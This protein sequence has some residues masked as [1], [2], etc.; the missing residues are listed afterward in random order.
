MKHLPLL[1]LLVLGCAT[2]DPPAPSPS[3]ESTP[4]RRR[5]R[6]PR[7]DADA[8]TPAPPVDP[9]LPST[10]RLAPASAPTVQFGSPVITAS[11][12][13]DELRG[14]YLPDGRVVCDGEVPAQ[15]ASSQ[16]PYEPSGAM[17][18]R[19]FEPV[20]PAVLAC[21]P[22]GDADGRFL[23]R[24][25]VS[26]T[27]LPQEVAFPEGTTEATATCVGRALCGLRLTAFRAVFVTVPYDFQ[28]PPA[29]PPAEE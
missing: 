24:V 26:G 4:R 27:G 16:S 13:N 1:A 22:P 11:A 2:T 7:A 12:R 15:R 8:S 10:P 23:V 14:R 28:V 19:G 9:T 21:A 20:T 25:R 6:R 3:A 18:A 17:I 29:A 5:R